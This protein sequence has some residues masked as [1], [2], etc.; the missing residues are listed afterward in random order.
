MGKLGDAPNAAK[1][2]KIE[3]GNDDVICELI[4]AAK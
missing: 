1:A 3:G 2:D 4:V